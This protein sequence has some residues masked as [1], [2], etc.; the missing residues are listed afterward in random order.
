MQVQ[1]STVT[2]TVMRP[3]TLI[4]P[5]TLTEATDPQLVDDALAAFYEAAKDAPGALYYS[6]DA[7]AVIAA[8]MA[9]GGAVCVRY[10]HDGEVTARV[11][12]P[13]AMV[14][15]KDNHITVRGFCTYRREVKSFRVDRMACVHLFTMPGE[16]PA[17]A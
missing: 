16:V 4:L 17:A 12:F 9:E 1:N 8:A 2:L 13:S 15:T 6:K 11:I 3:V 10:E 7:L 14:F 5:R